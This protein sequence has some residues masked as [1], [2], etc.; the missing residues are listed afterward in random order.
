MKSNILQRNKFSG[1]EGPH[2]DTCMFHDSTS[3]HLRGVHPTISNFQ[4]ACLNL[5]TLGQKGPH[6]GKQRLNWKKIVSVFRSPSERH[7]GNRDA[8][9]QRPGRRD[10]LEADARHSR[11]AVVQQ[12]R[13]RQTPRPSTVGRP[14]SE[15]EGATMQACVHVSPT[16]AR[17]NTEPRSSHVEGSP[18][19]SDQRD[20]M[21]F[22]AMFPT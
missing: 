3:L 12:V 18:R 13:R 10:E 2:P 7:G 16:H 8:P 19:V 20:L 4:F 21:T 14:V 15:C 5:F 1:C 11:T 9:A 6:F 17:K 22:A